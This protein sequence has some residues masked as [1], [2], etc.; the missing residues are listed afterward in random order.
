MKQLATLLIPITTLF[1][2]DVYVVKKDINY[3]ESIS[4]DNVELKSVDRV[5]NYCTPINTLDS[6]MVA[7]NYLKVG[8][9]LCKKSI[10]KV[11]KDRIIY[12]FGGIEII[13]NTK[14]LKQGKNYIRVRNSKG[15][16]EKIDISGY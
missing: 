9:I 13:Q 12:D 14:I 2:Q 7:K 6:S 10:R 3:K 16:I 1:S 8:K 4:L 15:K 11:V 5:P